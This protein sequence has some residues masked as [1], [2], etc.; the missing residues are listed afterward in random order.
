M[1]IQAVTDEQQF[2]NLR[3]PWTDLLKTSAN[4]SLYSTHEWLSSWWR[5]LKQGK[6]LLILAGYEGDRLVALAPFVLSLRESF[7]QAVLMGGRVTDYKDCIVED[8]MDRSEV[9]QAL[10]HELLRHFPV[11]F[12]Q[13][14]GLLENSPNFAPLMAALPHQGVYRPVAEASDVSVYVKVQGT[15]DEYWHRLGRGYRENCKRQMGRLRGLEGGYVFH[16]P[17]TAQEVGQYVELLLWQKIE[18]WRHTK[19]ERTL[20]ENESVKQFYLDVA[21]RMFAAGWAQAPALLVQG[22]VASV[23]FGAVYG[24]KYFSCQHSFDET[25]APY[26]VGRLLNMEIL[27]RA[28]ENSWHEM[29]LGLGAEPY[30]FDYKPEVRKM[31]RVTLFKAGVRGQAAEYWFHRVRPRLMQV[32]QGD[33]W[34]HSASLWVKSHML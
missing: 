34:V 21:Q 18:R 3:E 13:L 15:L 31:Y 11:D 22:K 26:S 9:L 32:T 30:K 10:L 28:Y 16:F 24:G 27:R 12:V 6:Q 23:D 17:T 7:H 1:R 19:H 4:T 2:L 29:D 5:C 8:G 20:I 25:F 14:S 33:S